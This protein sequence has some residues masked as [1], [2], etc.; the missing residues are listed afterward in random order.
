MRCWQHSSSAETLRNSE[1]DQDAAFAFHAA[2]GSS[3]AS[4]LQLMCKEGMEA[5]PTTVWKPGGFVV[6]YRY[7]ERALSRS[8]TRKARRRP[9]PSR[10]LKPKTLQRCSHKLSRSVAAQILVSQAERG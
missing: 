7:E 8:E 2:D 9:S 6:R 1:S 4:C 10:R 5:F 3:P